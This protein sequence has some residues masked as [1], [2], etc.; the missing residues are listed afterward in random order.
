MSKNTMNQIGSFSLSRRHAGLAA[1][2]GLGTL[3]VSSAAQASSSDIRTV[4]AQYRAADAQRLLNLVNEYRAEH[5]LGALRHSATVASVMD[6]EAKRQFDQGFFSHGTEFLNNPKVQG[7]SFVREVIALSYN[8][9]I[10]QLLAFWK[11]SPAHNAA[12]LAPSANTCGIGLCYGYGNNLPWRVL[13]NMGIYRYDT[14]GPSDIQNT[15]SGASAAVHPSGFKVRG[16]IAAGYYRGGGAAR[17]GEPTMNERGGLLDGGAWQNFN[18]DGNTTTF[19]WS[20]Y[21]GAHPVF[22]QGAIGRFWI[23][24]DCENTLGYPTMAEQGGLVDGGY[25]QVFNKSGNRTKVLWSPATGAHSVYESGAIGAEFARRG[26]ENGV[27]YPTTEE[28]WDGIFVRQNFSGGQ[29][30]S[31]NSFTGAVSVA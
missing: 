25:Y 9:D 5:G 14:D 13:G 23:D 31:W 15:V 28:Y 17:F 29:V 24:N 1:L 19:M 12:I 4:S 20:N 3:A 18:K 26:F 11:S 21:T 8:D 30:I 6:N 10:S 2:V 16:G 7:Y 27:G 22:R